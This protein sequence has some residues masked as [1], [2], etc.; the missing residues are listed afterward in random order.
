[1]PI[2]RLYGPLGTEPVDGFCIVPSVVMT[3]T[4]P[5]VPLQAVRDNKIYFGARMVEAFRL[6]FD[7]NGGR[8]GLE[9]RQR[10][11]ATT[12]KLFLFDASS[13]LNRLQ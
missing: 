8:V 12:R 10:P 11:N 7:Y 1:M 6:F 4:Y 13:N 2:R 3:E 5:I 9:N